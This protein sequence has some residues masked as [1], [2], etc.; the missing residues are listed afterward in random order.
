MNA[1]I[2]HLFLKLW[3]R[4]QT[5]ADKLNGLV[6]NLIIGLLSQFGEHI[7]DKEFNCVRVQETEQDWTN[8]GDH[9]YKV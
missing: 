8:K 9:V 2:F 5:V 4:K 7:N 1:V 3:C 6:I